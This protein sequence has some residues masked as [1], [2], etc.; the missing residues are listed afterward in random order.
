[1][2]TRYTTQYSAP[3]GGTWD[4]DVWGKIRRQIES[5][6]SAAQASAADLDNA[7]LS[8]QALLATAYFN[9]RA[10]DSLIILLQRTTNEYK[11]TYDIVTNQFNV[12][13]SVTEG[14]V[15]TADANIRTTEAQLAAARSSRAQFEHATAVLIGRPPA[16]LSV[17][18]RGLATNIPRIP[19][20]VTSTLL[21]RRPDIAAA[22]RTIQQQNALIGVAEAGYFPDI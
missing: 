1:L 9:L 2:N 22:E 12:D 19:V 7:K 16:E 21:E 14:D 15:A 3:I 5:N 13:Y 18:Q 10:S 17:A 11:K 6:T 4:L 8:Q 20:T